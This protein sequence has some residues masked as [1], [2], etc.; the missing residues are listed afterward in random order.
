MIPGAGSG[1]LPR[2]AGLSSEEAALR[3][4]KVGA[5]RLPQ[6]RPVPRWRKLLAEMTHFFAIMLWVAAGLAYVAGMP[7]LAVAI[8][9]VILVNGIFA[10]I[11]Q[12]RAQRAAARLRELL[13]AIVSVRR[14]GRI[15][16]V[17]TTELVPDDVVVLVAGDRVPAE[18]PLPSPWTGSRLF[19]LGT[20]LTAWA[21]R[22]FPPTEIPA[23]YNIRLATNP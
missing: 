3:L 4:K 1:A 13:P 18:R 19:D 20:R 21:A 23:E 14:D 11:Q 8:V 6:V 10:Y 12:E 15:V 22:S 16:K 9:V 7:Q 2:A 17:H 5:N